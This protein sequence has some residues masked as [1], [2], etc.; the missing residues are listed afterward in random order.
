MALTAS[1]LC[2]GRRS[3]WGNRSRSAALIASNRPRV[4]PLF[5]IKRQRRAKLQASTSK[6][7]RNPKLPI[8]LSGPSVHLYLSVF[9]HGAFGTAF[10][11]KSDVAGFGSFGINQFAFVGFEVFAVGAG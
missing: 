5:M 10:G 1:S 6:P 9:I 11:I 3:R 7:Q 8:L 2:M 4:I